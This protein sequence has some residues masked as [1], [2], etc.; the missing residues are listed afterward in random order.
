[1]AGNWLWLL[2]DKNSTLP[3]SFGLMVCNRLGLCALCTCAT[4][5]T[6]ERRARRESRK[7]KE[8]EDGRS[9]RKGSNAPVLFIAPDFVCH[10]RKK[11]FFHT[12]TIP[13]VLPF[14]AL[15]ASL[16]LKGVRVH[17]CVCMHIDRRLCVI[18]PCFFMPPFG[19]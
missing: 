1:M 13:T 12:H 10:S 14:H 7:K 5:S 8:R 9:R 19:Q 15:M 3:H 16:K 18:L 11:C 17:M 4:L 2:I 6:A